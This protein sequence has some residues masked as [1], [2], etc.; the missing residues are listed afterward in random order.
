MT[1]GGREAGNLDRQHSVYFY[2][3][4]SDLGENVASFL[5]EGLL[6]GMP[7]IVIA[8]PIHSAA[9]QNALN[10]RS[11]DVARARHLGDLVLLDAEET[12][13]A[14]MYNRML[15]EALFRRHATQLIEQ[16]LRGR[17]RTAFRAYG[18][19]VD[20][21]WHRNESDAAMRLEVLWNEL[22]TTY[23]FSLMCGYA[24][25]DFSDESS[26]LEEVCRH[27][28]NLIGREMLP[29]EIAERLSPFG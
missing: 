7:A 10:T 19:M 12:L 26:T 22:Q 21:L 11:I 17:G 3:D 15:D 1:E 23:S 16:T 20:V 5:N 28:T 27:H 18:E 6:A 13:G 9:I 29:V 2:N 8:T 4:A 14:F 25:A 24:V